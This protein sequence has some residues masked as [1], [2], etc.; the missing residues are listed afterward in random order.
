MK[1]LN[2]WN[3]CPCKVLITIRSRSLMDLRGGCI[4]VSH[5]TQDLPSDLFLLIF[6]PLE[7][8]GNPF[9][10]STSLYSWYYKVIFDNI[11]GFLFLG[12]LFFVLNSAAVEMCGLVWRRI[13]CGHDSTV[14]WS[15]FCLPGQNNVRK[16]RVSNYVLT[17]MIHHFFFN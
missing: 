4:A 2:R 9:N 6:L 3:C 1:R 13:S 7:E 12:F 15:W 11:E 16:E 5:F 10:I 14:I 17:P 8:I